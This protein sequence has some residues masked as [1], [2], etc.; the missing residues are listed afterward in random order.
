M[1]SKL[2]R[3]L[4]QRTYPGAGDVD[5]CWVVASIQAYRA[6]VPGGGTPGKPTI[7]TFRTA[8]NVPDKPGPTGSDRDHI[9]RAVTRLGWNVIATASSPQFD[10]F[11]ASLRQGKTASVAV[12]SGMLPPALQYSFR[13][14]HQISVDIDAAGQLWVVNPLQPK[15]TAPQK[16]SAAALQVAVLGFAADH[17]VQAVLFAPPAV[18][19]APGTPP[20]PPPDPT[21]FSQDDLDEAVNVAVANVKA[22][23]H[24]VFDS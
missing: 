2:G 24:I 18:I 11:M 21:P 9:L 7:L 14:K 10:T 22:T 5:D 15:G 19:P 12:D 16:I 23:A 6:V 4:D 3:S 20:P 8:A 17:R 13:G 1:A